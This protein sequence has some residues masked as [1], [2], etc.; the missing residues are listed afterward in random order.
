MSIFSRTRTR[1]TDEH[2]EGR[3]LIVTTEIIP[4]IGRLIKEKQRQIFH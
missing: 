4:D 2:L 3:M 1:I